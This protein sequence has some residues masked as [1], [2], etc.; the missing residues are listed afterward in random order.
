[1]SYILDALRKADGERNLG[2]APRLDFKP[3]PESRAGR[4]RLLWIAVAALGVLVGVLGA[5]QISQLRERNAQ[6]RQAVAEPQVQAGRPAAAETRPRDPAP[7]V[8]VEA[9]EIP[10]ETPVETP[11]PEK[12]RVQVSTSSGPVEIE[13]PDEQ[14]PV[15]RVAPEPVAPPPRP[16]AERAPEAPVSASGPQPENAQPE[17]L[18]L[19]SPAQLAAEWEGN[20]AVMPEVEEE[21]EPEP[22]EEEPLTSYNGLPTA[23]RSSIGELSMNAHVYSSTPGRGFVIINGRRYRPGDRLEEGP[24][25]EAIRPEGAVLDYR[26]ERFLLP[27]PR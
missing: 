19:P 11:A 3:L 22:V 27:V 1:M 18:Q 9:S 12:R 21:F 14:A 15:R 13:M 6:S 10:V 4:S 8:V 24:V 7:A 25:L 26:G 17:P 2:D 16:V 5:M 20:E 23:T